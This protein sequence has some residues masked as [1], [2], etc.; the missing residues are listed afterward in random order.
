[1]MLKLTKVRIRMNRLLAAL[2]VLLA[3]MAWC[4]CAAAE[5]EA[6]LDDYAK[7]TVQIVSDASGGAL[8][9]YVEN[10]QSLFVRLRMSEFNSQE[11]VSFLKANSPVDLTA[12]IDFAGD[13]KGSYP[14]EIYPDDYLHRGS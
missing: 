11:L 7:L 12:D 10:G 2:A 1:M 14:T 9:E 3:C 13:I 5:T 4:M 8:A 6:E